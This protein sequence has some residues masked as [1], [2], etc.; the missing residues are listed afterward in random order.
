MQKAEGFLLLRGRFSRSI[1]PNLY[2][3]SYNRMLYVLIKNAA[4]K[5]SLLN[6]IEEKSER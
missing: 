2:G 5:R 1:C 6:F 4:K 3:D